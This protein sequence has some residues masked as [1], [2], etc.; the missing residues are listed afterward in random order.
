MAHWEH[1]DEPRWRDFRFNQPYAKGLARLEDEVLA[2]T[3]FDPCHP[4]AV[5]HDAGDGAARRTRGRRGEI[6]RSRYRNTA[7]AN[8]GDVLPHQARFVAPNDI[9]LTAPICGGGSCPDFN[10]SSDAIVPWTGG[11][12]GKVSVTYQTSTDTGSKT[13]TCSFD[14]IAGSGTV[15]TAALMLLDVGTASGFL[16]I[17]LITAVNSKSIMVGAMPTFLG[18]EGTPVEGQFSTTD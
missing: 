8:D 6:R 2:K 12:A 4:V 3:D 16:G 1:R 5:G 15:P 7:A 10:R 11:G 18:V 13:L 17:E 14:A 9:T